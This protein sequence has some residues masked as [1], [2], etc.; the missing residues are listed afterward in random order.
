MTPLTDTDRYRVETGHRIFVQV[1]A[2]H[3]DAL[4]DAIIQADPL[5]YGAYEHVSFTTAPGTQ[6]FLSTGAGRNVATPGAVQIPCVE[7]SVFVAASTGAL[8]AVL[9]AIYHI[10]PYEEPVIVLQPAHRCLHRPGLDEENPN[11]F[12]N[13]PAEDW[14]PP[15]HR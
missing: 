14:I 1:P 9:R 8:E 15:A 4:L 12:W 7:V 2:P 6:R 10:H 13:R 11:R 3:V 5:G